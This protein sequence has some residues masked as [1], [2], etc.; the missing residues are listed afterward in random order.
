[1]ARVQPP[2]VLPNGTIITPPDDHY[3]YL[4]TEWVC[5]LF[6]ALYALSSCEGSLSIIMQIPKLIDN[7]HTLGPGG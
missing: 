2:I 7:R 3:H 6:V 1:M 5:A 4:P